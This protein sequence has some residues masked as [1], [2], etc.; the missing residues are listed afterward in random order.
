MKRLY[1]LFVD[2]ISGEEVYLYIDKYGDKF[3]ANYNR[4]FFRVPK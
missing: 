1:C 3:M 4:F 2:S